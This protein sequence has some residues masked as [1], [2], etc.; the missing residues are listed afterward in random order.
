[1]EI[2]S[3]EKKQNIEPIKE[4]NEL[5]KSENYSWKGYSRDRT[6]QEIIIQIGKLLK[7]KIGSWEKKKLKNRTNQGRPLTIQEAEPFNKNYSE[8]AIQ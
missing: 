7:M 6:I 5:F 4:E 8:R 3:S 1:M 2:G